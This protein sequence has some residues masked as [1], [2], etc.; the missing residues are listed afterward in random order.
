M[1]DF[2]KHLADSMEDPKFT[3]EWDAQATE[4]EIMRKVAQA[5]IDAGI[6]QKELAERCNMRQSNLS[7]LENGNA[8]PSVET[9][10]RIAHGLGKRLEIS[11][12]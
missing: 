7:R 1:S 4:R 5:R 11:F 3:A 9:L 6:S 8:N 2:R 10:G 12:V